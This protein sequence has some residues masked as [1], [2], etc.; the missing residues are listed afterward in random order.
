MGRY[1]L[2]LIFWQSLDIF[3]HNVISYFSFTKIISLVLGLSLRAKNNNKKVVEV[4]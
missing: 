1:N 2:F 3:Y 4:K